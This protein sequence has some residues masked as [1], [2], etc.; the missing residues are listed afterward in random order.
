MRIGQ[1]S[2]I[3]AVSKVVGSVAGFVATLYFA[4]LLGAGVLGTYSLVIAVVGWLSIA[5]K[6]GINAAIQKRMTEGEEP[7]EFFT[8]GV[9]SLFALFSIIVVLVFVFR[10]PLA[11]Y[12]GR[13]A[14]GFVALLLFASLLSALSLSA[15][16]GTHLVHVRGLLIPVRMIL[17]SGTQIALVVL[18]FELAGMLVG[19]ALGSVLVGLV[20][21]YIAG[22]SIRLPSRRHFE[23][24]VSYA[25][26]SWLGSLERRTTGWAD[27]TILGLFVSPG[28]IGVYSVAWTISTFLQIFGSAI[29]SATFPEI[30]SATADADSQVAAPIVQDALRYA[31]LILIPGLVGAMILGPRILRIYGEE[32]AVGGHVLTILVAA[33][34]FRSYQEQLVTT[35]SAVD[36][37]DLTFRVN[38]ISVTS[39]LLLNLGL[40]YL[41]GWVGAAVA[42]ALAS[43][44]RLALSYHY[45]SNLI[46]LDLPFADV[47]K[48]VVAA[49]VTGVVATGCLWI[50]NTYALV[51]LNFVVVGITAGLGA[52]AYFG[53]LLGISAAFRRTVRNNLPFDV[54]IPR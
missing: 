37:P 30:S 28:L 4:R 8:A 46:D 40:I 29:S 19:E 5:G 34:L 36:R 42:T 38:A 35:L 17:Q 26:Y 20:G 18:G 25:K 39:N 23:Q 52:A 45:T 48:Q 41:Y 15:L 16:T 12:V 13:P 2:L 24:L 11:A 9:C 22:P 49:A 3:V 47:G 51:G 14:A 21:I 53:V 31:G 7:D 44:I 43:G 54:P 10:E 6:V 33:L 1:T 32:F 50:E 27:I